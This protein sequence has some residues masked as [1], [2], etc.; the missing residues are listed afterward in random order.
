M[1]RFSSF[2]L[3]QTER[4][5]H[6]LVQYSAPELLT[7]CSNVEGCTSKLFRSFEV[8][9]NYEN[10]TGIINEHAVAK[11]DNICDG[12]R[13]AELGDTVISKSIEKCSSDPVKCDTDNMCGGHLWFTYTSKIFPTLSVDIR[14]VFGE[15][16]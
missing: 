9:N 1:R 10:R 13:H 16:P 8:E 7:E 14:Y 2:N 5:R 4:C 6:C 12:C 15:L 3:F 11:C